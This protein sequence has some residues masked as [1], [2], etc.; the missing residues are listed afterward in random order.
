MF[1][2]PKTV[3]FC[4]ISQILTRVNF[5]E[6][7]SVRARIFSSH[8]PLMFITENAQL[9]TGVNLHSVRSFSIH[10]GVQTVS[11]AIRK[12]RHPHLPNADCIGRFCR[13]CI[14]GCRYFAP[15]S[16]QHFAFFAQPLDAEEYTGVKEN[17]RER[18]RERKRKR[19]KEGGRK[20]QTRVSS[21]FE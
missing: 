20:K 9:T 11:R 10:R 6:I 2:V 7:F 8:L 5:K 19:G 14:R 12:T 16:F 1:P 15:V 17:E 3:V 18:K 21:D 4:G 13:S